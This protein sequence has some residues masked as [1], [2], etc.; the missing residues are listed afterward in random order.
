M[1]PLAQRNLFHD[2]VRLTVTLTGI[3]FSV[4]L[5]VVQ[6]GLF[7]GFTTA[8][9]NLIDH[10]GADLWITSKNVPYVEQGVAFS[11]RK[12]NQVRAVPG[13]ADAQKIIAH[14]TQWKRHDGAEDSVQIVGINVDDSLERPWNLVEGRVED[15]KSPDAII[16]DELYKSKLGVTR[17][18]EVFEIGGHRAR[19]VGFTRGIRSFTTSPYVFTTFKNAQNY[20]G[21]REDQTMFILVKV[22]PGASL[23]QVRRGLLDH[24]KDVE[25][26]T[27]AEFSHM[28]TFY[29]MFTTGAGVAV[30]IAAVLGLVV[31]FV[32]VAQTIYAT[33]MD[34][35]REYGTLKAMGA[36]NSYVYKV[37][38]KQAAISAVIGYALGMIV[39]GFVVHASQAGGAA[40][41]MPPSMAGGMFFVT[42]LMCVGAAL[43]S[44]NKVTRIDPATVFKG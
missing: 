32:V 8:T 24:I 15:L 17:V 6:L 12:L 5:I 14:W 7:F 41:L 19:V 29:W 23:E 1:P 16:L 39:S 4:V 11:E 13:T 38:M 3:V 36:P 2:K 9:S 42:L 44:I 43:V 18:G 28:T 22:A 25:V 31:G 27:T 35:I 10:S 30:L 26:F 20:T 21:T 33:T 40:I 34:H 37:I